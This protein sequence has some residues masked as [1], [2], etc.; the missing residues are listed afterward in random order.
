MDLL[1]L[2]VT[3]LTL[4]IETTGGVMDVLVPRNTVVPAKARAGPAS[5][6]ARRQRLR[7]RT[8]PASVAR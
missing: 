1:L 5:G 2:D 7:R 8:R 3:P 6:A 4:G